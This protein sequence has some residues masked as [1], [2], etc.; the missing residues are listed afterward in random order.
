MEA[1]GGVLS[2]GARGVGDKRGENINEKVIRF[3]LSKRRW[4][5]VAIATE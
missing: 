1:N 4:S 5:P 3:S 2:C